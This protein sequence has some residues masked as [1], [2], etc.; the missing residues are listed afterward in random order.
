MKS[1]MEEASSISKAIDRAW[2]RA[3]KPTKFTVRI[4]EEPT[5]NLFGLT[6]K[7][8]KIAFFFDERAV[9]EAPQPPQAERRQRQE[10]P[11]QRQP[12]R[13]QPR[14]QRPQQ[15]ARRVRPEWNDELAQGAK[16]WILQLLSKIG[17]SHIAFSTKQDGNLLR[18]T[19]SNSLTGTEA[20]DR[21]LYSSFASLIMTTLRQRF[22]RQLKHLKVV[23]TTQ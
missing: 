8:A 6:V 3:G 21:M 23:L 19:F 14:E 9:V 15:T 22:K 13:P 2:N 18:V 11:Q 1:I 10:Q 5:H 17:L 12:E 20:K 4:L 16:E 7:S